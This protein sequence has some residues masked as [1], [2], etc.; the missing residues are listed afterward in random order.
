MT[1]ILKKDR[2]FT[3]SSRNTQLCDSDD[4]T[5]TRAKSF[6]NPIHFLF[7]SLFLISGTFFPLVEESIAIACIQSAAAG[8]DHQ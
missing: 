5:D 4:G 3:F 6:A 7:N 2:L 8:K 1:F